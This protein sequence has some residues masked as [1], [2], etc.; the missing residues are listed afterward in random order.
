[1]A[2]S[3]WLTA[4]PFDHIAVA[5]WYE[6]I[7]HGSCWLRNRKKMQGSQEGFWQLLPWNTFICHCDNEQ[8]DTDWKKSMRTQLSSANFHWALI[9]RHAN[10][11]EV[12]WIFLIVL[13]NLINHL[14]FRHNKQLSICHWYCSHA[15]QEWMHSQFQ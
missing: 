10:A 11:L 8:E 7:F 2:T 4:S 1:M 6:V 14:H 12:T 15:Y 13:D 9:N 3:Q 5:Y